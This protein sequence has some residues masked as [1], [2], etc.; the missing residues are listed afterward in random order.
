MQSKQGASAPAPKLQLPAVGSVSIE[1]PKNQQQTAVT[2][3]VFAVLGVWSLAQ[4]RHG[5]CVFGGGGGEG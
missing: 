1:A 2:A 4:V 5:K 3:G